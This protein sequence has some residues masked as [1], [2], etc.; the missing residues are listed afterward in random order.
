M[1]TRLLFVLLTLGIFFTPPCFSKKCS[2]NLMWIKNALDEGPY[3]FPENLPLD[4]TA[5]TID[6]IKEWTEKNKEC[7]INFW[8]NKQTVSK[9]QLSNTEKLIIEK[10]G[11]KIKLRDIWNLTTI[12]SHPHLFKES[13]PTKLRTDLLE[14]IIIDELTR[15][16]VKTRYVIYADMNFLPMDY[17]TLFDSQTQSALDKFGLVL[18]KGQ[19][20]DPYSTGFLIID[21]QNKNMC[22]LYR[23]MIVNEG[24]KIS[25]EVLNK[26]DTSDTSLEKN[27]YN[28]YTDLFSQ[29]VKKLPHGEDQSAKIDVILKDIK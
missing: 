12:I 16:N 6:R 23:E 26:K 29:Y 20:D 4:A 14:S 22:P 24:I 21:G 28:K 25:K 11:S 13:L 5:K 2:I 15:R 9:K 18:A 10:L 8:Y 7:D 17:N 27:I 3:V 19:K 1:F